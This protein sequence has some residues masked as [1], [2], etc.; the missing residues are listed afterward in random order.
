MSSETVLPGKAGRW[1]SFA[2]KYP[3]WWMAAL[4]LGLG[5][6][7]LIARQRPPAV[8]YATA[9]RGP[10]TLT[11]AASGKVE[12]DASDLGFVGSGTIVEEL[13]KEGDH[14]ESNQLLAR[15][16]L[17]S[18]PGVDDVIQAPYAGTIVTVY[19]KIGETV[20]PGTPVLRIVRRGGVTVTA[21]LDSEDAAWV[22]P[23]DRFVCRAG[24]Y[25]ARAWPLEVESVGREA[26]PRED[27][28]G[29]ARQVRAP[30]RVLD[31]GFTLPVG[32]AVDIDGDVEIAGDVLQVPAP[33]IV[34]EDER[35]FVWRLVNGHVERVEVKLGPNNFRYVA[36]TDGLKAGD[37]VV[38]EGKTE[39]KPGQKVSAT[40][41]QESQP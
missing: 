29:S 1:N 2:A 17:T 24:G 12:G 39:L 13:V 23:G 4:L 40:A 10:M 36:I 9:R 15:I 35:T 37:A 21:Y 18:T 41:W 31:A 33:A 26:V 5:V 38:L 11:I 14:V 27:V 19:R 22:K 8:T 16:N 28:L 7:W 30:M 34:R 3:R 20:G 6:L 32:T 25:L